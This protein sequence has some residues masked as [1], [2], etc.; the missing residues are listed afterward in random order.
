MNSVFLHIFEN[1]LSV[2]PEIK[3]LETLSFPSK[4]L[5]RNLR[6]DFYLP[7]ESKKLTGPLDVLIIN[8][9]QDLQT[10]GFDSILA[11][12]YRAEAIRP[13][14]LYWNSCRSAPE[15]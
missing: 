3:P 8:D 13:N 12:L 1:M 7:Q 10:M 11:K 9:G 14:S 15:I 6:I 4:I 5:E 2:N